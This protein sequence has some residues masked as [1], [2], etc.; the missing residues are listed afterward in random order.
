V[1][2]RNIRRDSLERLRR[3]EKGKTISEDESRRSQQQLQQVTDAYI[4]KMNTLRQD[5]EAEVMEL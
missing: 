4:N 3:M 1:A 2:V 5:K